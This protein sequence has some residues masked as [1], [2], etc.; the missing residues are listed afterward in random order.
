M[1]QLHSKSKKTRQGGF[2][3]LETLIACIVLIVGVSGVMALF[4]VAAMRNANQ[5]DDAT[6]TTEYAQDKME[7][8]MTLSFADTISDTTA[9]PTCTPAVSPAVALPPGCTPTS[10]G[11]TTT[12][13]GLNALGTTYGSVYPA[14]AVTGYVD[15]IGSSGTYSIS[16]AGAQYIR[17]WK[18]VDSSV[19]DATT[20]GPSIK[21]ITVS[22]L[23]LR[24]LGRT[25]GNTTVFSPKTILISQKASF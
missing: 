6:R 15:Y 8:L 7:Q 20:G 18:I 12:G 10:S 17:Q 2:S 22:V 16:S 4:T 3:L 9:S 24:T 23:S 21:T 5:G 14:A 11:V 19:A 1:N 13:L 25:N